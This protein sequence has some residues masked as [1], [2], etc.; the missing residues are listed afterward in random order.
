M[1]ISVSKDTSKTD[2][3]PPPIPISVSKDTSKTDWEPPPMPISVSKQV[4]LTGNHLQYL[5]LFLKK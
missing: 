2:W 4:K 3:E 1:P 5:F